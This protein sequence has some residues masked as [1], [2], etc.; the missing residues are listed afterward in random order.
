MK[1]C[2]SLERPNP[3]LELSASFAHALFTKVSLAL[4][5]AL[6]FAVRLTILASPRQWDFLLLHRPYQRDLLRM[7]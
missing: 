5:S 3:V 7:C 6:G 2:Q 4:T 1:L